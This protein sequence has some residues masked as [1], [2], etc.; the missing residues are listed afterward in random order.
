MRKKRKS[1][2]RKKGE[3][4]KKGRKMEKE[5]GE[6]GEKYGRRERVEGEGGGGRG[7]KEVDGDVELNV[8]FIGKD[9][10][11]HGVRGVNSQFHSSDYFPYGFD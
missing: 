1:G 5:G 3:E 6:Q 9:R 10:M 8:L 4:E 11:V 7:Q 2:R